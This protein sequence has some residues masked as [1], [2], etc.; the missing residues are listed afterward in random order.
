M[1]LAEVG[2]RTPSNLFLFV[3]GAM[4]ERSVAIA[5]NVSVFDCNY[6]LSTIT[7]GLKL[8]KVLYYC[9]KIIHAECSPSDLSRVD[10]QRLLCSKHRVLVIHKHRSPR[11]AN[12]TC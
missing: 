11:P 7:N 5:I 2:T 8:F 9:L 3:L 6:E 12:L 1:K 10:I 4:Q